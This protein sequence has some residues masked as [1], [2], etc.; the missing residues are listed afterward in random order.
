MTKKDVI[1]ISDI[2]SVLIRS[3]NAEEFVTYFGPYC[4]DCHGCSGHVADLARDL[5]RELRQTH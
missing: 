4:G 1:F 2:S 5:R 3:N